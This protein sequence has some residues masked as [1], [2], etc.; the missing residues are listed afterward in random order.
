MPGIRKT[1]EHC[2]QVKLG[3]CPMKIAARSN[4][5]VEGCDSH[6]RARAGARQAGMRT[7]VRALFASCFQ[8]TR[9]PALLLAPAAPGLRCGPASAARL[10]P[11]LPSPIRCPAVPHWREHQEAPAPRRLAANGAAAGAARRRWR[12]RSDLRLV[13]V[14]GPGPVALREIALQPGQR[15]GVRGHAQPLKLGRECHGWA[16][17]RG[18]CHRRGGRRGGFLGGGPAGRAY[19]KGKGGGAALRLRVLQQGRG[20]SRGQE[21]TAGQGSWCAKNVSGTCLQGEG[22]QL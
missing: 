22:L 13:P 16:G 9:W 3:S 4:S 20:D 8:S 12:R 17:G 2:G 21:K 5:A 7:C 18:G 6:L 11:A 19:S 14:T 15:S 1:W 10:Q